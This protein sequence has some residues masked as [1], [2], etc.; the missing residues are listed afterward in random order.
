MRLSKPV[1][2][3][4]I[5][6]GPWPQQSMSIMS[7]GLVLDWMKQQG[8]IYQRHADHLRELAPLKLHPILD[9]VV[10]RSSKTLLDEL[11]ALLRRNEVG[12]RTGGGV[13]GR[14]AEFLTAQRGV[15]C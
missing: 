5:S 6:H 12:E 8:T 1:E 14:A 7:H 10:E 15:N 11:E 3:D 13:L 4:R 2:L 9:E